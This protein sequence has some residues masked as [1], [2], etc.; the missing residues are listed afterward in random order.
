[1]LAA[2]YTTLSLSSGLTKATTLGATAISSEAIPHFPRRNQVSANPILSP[3][4]RV[5]PFHSPSSE[6]LA[7]RNGSSVAPPLGLLPAPRGPAEGRLCSPRSS[8]GLCRQQPRIQPSPVL[9]PPPPSCAA[10]A[11]K[12]AA[13]LHRIGYAAPGAGI[14]STAAQSCTPF[15][16]HWPSH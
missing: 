3:L 8:A 10:G 2:S 16:P 13:S 6:S 1:M 15:R 11:S 5:L 12:R 14:H 7:Q 9:L 4:P